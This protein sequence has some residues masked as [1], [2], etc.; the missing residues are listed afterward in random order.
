MDD[1]VATV[2]DVGDGVSDAAESPRESAGTHVLVIGP[3]GTQDDV[4]A[5]RLR[6]SGY[7]TRL[8]ATGRLGLALAEQRIPEVV[9][10]DRDLSDLKT[11]T[12]CAHLRGLS[13]TMATIVVADGADQH[14]V[15]H[16]LD[17]GAE[18]CVASRS[19]MSELMARVRRT[20]RRRGSELGAAPELAFAAVD[21]GELHID[22]N[23]YQVTMGR[24][25]LKL[26]RREFRV[27]V[28][29]ARNA[30]VTLTYQR[31]LLDLWGEAESTEARLS[32]L[33]N[34]MARLRNAMALAGTG[35]IVVNVPKVGYRLAVPSTE[36]AVPT[37]SVGA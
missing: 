14:E 28:L 32:K 16:W 18:D 8:A 13:D 11:S 37:A 23:T 1:A 21:A 12:L 27:L 29:L 30:G 7:R 17:N 20:L 22:L 25:E 3:V 31:L 26:T 10:V 5:A 19:A 34:S 9:I 24:T 6:A 35:P 2:V 33:R 15:A 4:L 36:R